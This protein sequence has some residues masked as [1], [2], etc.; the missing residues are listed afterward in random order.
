VAVVIDASMALAWCIESE[1]TDASIA[2]LDRLQSERGFVPT[3][4]SF[5]VANALLVAERRGRLSGTE[6][7]RAFQLLLELPISVGERTLSDALATVLPLAR[8]AS[9]SVYDAS[10]LDLAAR[11]GLPLATLDERMRA[12]ARRLGV[13]LV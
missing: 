12:A 6:I 11:E 13:P 4:W 7:E 3:I 9:L 10:Y 5:E 2:A 8:R 1:S